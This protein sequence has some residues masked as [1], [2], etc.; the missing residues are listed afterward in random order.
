MADRD[1]GSTLRPLAR[2]FRLASPDTKSILASLPCDVLLEIAKCLPCLA[3]VLHMCLTSSLM[4][5]QVMEVL[6]ASVDL[7]S[8]YQCSRTLNMLHNRPEVARHVRQLVVRPDDDPRRKRRRYSPVDGYLVSAAVR[9]A[10]LKFDALHTFIWDGEDLP[11]YDDMWF[12]LRISCPQLHT[13]GTTIGPVP[14]NPRSHLFDFSNLRGFSLT[15]RSGFYNNFDSWDDMPPFRPLWDMLIKRCPNLEVLTVDGISARPG[16]ARIL[17]SA[18]WPKLRTLVVGPILLQREA[19]LFNVQEKPPFATFLESHHNLRS[20]H[21]TSHAGGLSAADLQALDADALPE[22]SEFCGSLS[23]LQALPRSVLKSIKSARFPEP[24]LLR[25]VTPPLTVSMVLQTLSSLTH[26]SINFVLQSGY[27]DN[28]GV[29]KTIV[30]NCPLLTKL[31]IICSSQPAFYLD[32]F[33]KAI[34]SLSKL[35]VLSLTLVKVPGDEP[36]I[37]GAARIALSNPRLKKFNVSYISRYTISL[38]HSHHIYG[39]PVHSDAYETGSYELIC[40]R[41]GL[42]IKLTVYERR[43]QTFVWLHWVTRRRYVHDLRPPGHPDVLRK[44]LAHLLMEKGNAGE[45][46]RLIF[47]CCMLVVLAFTATVKT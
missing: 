37:K 45:E 36:M 46:M 14:P 43:S 26:L 44:G 7:S 9:Q 4:Y 41:H 42:P 20:L 47:F 11:P 19:H 22:L 33:S 21:L 23:Q 25:E 29:L 17:Y 6:Y 8:A 1:T 10:A 13:I 5:N 2:L 35:R 3:D 15:L 16:D 28:I 27:Y 30:S 40:D 34:R 31:D 32:A 18:R 38:R 12:A 39:T 24:L